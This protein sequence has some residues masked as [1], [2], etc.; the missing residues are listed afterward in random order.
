LK[1]TK[2]SGL[3]YYVSTRDANIERDSVTLAQYPRLTN[4]K[5]DNLTCNILNTYAD[6]ERD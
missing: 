5:A 3:S 6:R 1:I 2:I 4:N